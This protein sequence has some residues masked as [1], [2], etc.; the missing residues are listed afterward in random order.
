MRYTFDVYDIRCVRILTTTNPAEIT[1]EEGTLVEV[2]DN[3]NGSD[4][5][6]FTD[7][8]SFDEWWEQAVKAMQW[9]GKEDRKHMKEMIAR[10]EALKA[11]SAPLFQEAEKSVAEHVSPS[12]YKE[13]FV[14]G[15]RTHQWLETMM[16]TR[17]RTTERL[18]AALELQVR[19][20]LDREGE[21][22]VT[23]QELLKA[24]FYL[25]IWIAW[26]ANGEEPFDFGCMDAI[27][28]EF[29]NGGK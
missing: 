4:I 9:M 20:Y 15:D 23:V 10:N 7:E 3:L 27:I 22:D 12:H 21:K 29:Q 1:W 24:R 25:D 16:R 19:K 14:D 13:Y 5:P 26:L 2:T 18:T 28:E 6:G 8:D 11:D 17:F